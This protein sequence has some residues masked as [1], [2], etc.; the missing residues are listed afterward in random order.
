MLEVQD[1]CVGWG[2]SPVLRGLNLHLH[3]GQVISLGGDPGAGRSTL[4][5]ALL[6]FLPLQTGRVRLLGRDVSDWPTHQRVRLGLGYVAQQRAVFAQLTVRENLRLG[7][8]VG[9]APTRWGWAQTW[10]TFARLH[11][12]AD[13]PAG[14]L[15]GGEQQL[16]ALARA[17]MGDARVWVLDEPTEGLAPAALATLADLI[18]QRA[19]QGDALLLIDQKQTLAHRLSSLSL[20]LCCRSGRLLG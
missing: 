10:A 5:R 7:L 18:A 11:E 9:R 2:G 20:R 6:G 4:A 16:L 15:S 13:V 19:A 12:R 17:W 8:P 14:A 3:A 1:L